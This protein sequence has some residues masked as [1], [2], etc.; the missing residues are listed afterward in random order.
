MNIGLARTIMG[1]GENDSDAALRKK[2][3]ELALLHHPDRG[4]DEEKFRTVADAYQCIMDAKLGIGATPVTPSVVM[5]S[6]PASPQRERKRR[7]NPWYWEE[8][9]W[10]ER[11][12]GHLGY[13]TR[14]GRMR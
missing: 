3:R 11:E 4:G 12:F 5:I 2:W 14:N 1:L 7:V 13:W 6:G 8:Q 9:A 10:L